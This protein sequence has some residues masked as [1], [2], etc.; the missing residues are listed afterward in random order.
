MPTVQSQQ[1]NKSTLA[2][3]QQDLGEQETKSA[4]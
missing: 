2:E 4:Q 3:L 1:N